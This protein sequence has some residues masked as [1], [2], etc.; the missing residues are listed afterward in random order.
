M[1]ARRASGKGPAADRVRSRI[2]RDHG[3]AGSVL[4]G[5]GPLR[6]RAL[7]H[8]ARERRA[9]PP[10]GTRNPTGSLMSLPPQ[11]LSPLDGRY[12][13]TVE[14]LAEH[15]SEAGLNRARLPVEAEWLVFLTGHRM[16]GT[17]P[18]EA[19]ATRAL[20]QWVADFGQ[21]EIDELAVTEAP[22]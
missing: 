5:R 14:G 11:P 17:E 1:G 18:L 4:L 3:C 7:H 15:L 12:R 9:L 21:P 2:S 8:R 20:R 13:A 6:H 22:T 19:E 16:F 10:A